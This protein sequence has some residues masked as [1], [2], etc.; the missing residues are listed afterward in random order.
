VV[1]VAVVVVVVVVVEIVVVV[2]RVGMR[3]VVARRFVVVVVGVVVVVVELVASG[4]VVPIGSGVPVVVPL[5]EVVV[6]CAGG[7]LAGA[8]SASSP[9]PP[10]NAATV[11]K[12]VDTARPVSKRTTTG[13]RRAIPERSWAGGASAGRCS[14]GRSSGS[15][16][17]VPSLLTHRQ[18]AITPHGVS[19]R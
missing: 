7:L 6:T 11:A 3:V 12:T 1:G 17:L 10:A 2:V 13:A 14:S 8:G 4:S 9:E 19:A 16:I 15:D 5:V 18:L